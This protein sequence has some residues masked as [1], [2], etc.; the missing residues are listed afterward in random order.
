MWNIQ[1]GEEK[2]YPAVENCILAFAVYCAIL[3]TVAEP[4]NRGLH[5]NYRVFETFH[6]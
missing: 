1:N 4:I 5:E 3:S 6:S 2:K